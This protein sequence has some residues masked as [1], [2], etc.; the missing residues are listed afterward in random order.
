MDVERVSTGI[1]GLDK[2]LNG[3]LISGRAYLVRGEP[4]LGKTT[5]S[6]QFLME[7]VR[8]GENVLYITFEEPLALIE[9][10]MRAFG[11]RLDDPLFHGIDATPVG[12]KTHIFEDVYYEKFAQGFERLSAAVEE[13]I[14]ENNIRRVAVDPIT[15]LRLTAKNELE[16]RKAFLEF[17]KVFMHHDV[18]VI[19]T[20]S[21]LGGTPDVEDYLTSGVIELR[22]Y[23]VKGRAVRGIQILKFRGSAFD[24]DIRPYGFTS[25]GIE[26]YSSESLYAR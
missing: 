18:T 15:M 22:R 8:N 23:G 1:P 10:D 14:R 2:M 21:I 17:L 6:I 16:Y 9:R 5:L 13:K 11:F 26:V 20:S 7:G 3:G 25:R 12:K 24:G 4:G 19:I